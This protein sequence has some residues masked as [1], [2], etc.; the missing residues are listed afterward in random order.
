MEQYHVRQTVKGEKM[1][2][3]SIVVVVLLAFGLALV[4]CDNGMTRGKTKFEGRWV[5]ISYISQGYTDYSFTFSG[6]NFVFR[7]VHL[8]DS[9]RNG[10]YTGTFAFTDTYFTWTPT[11]GENW[12]G[13]SQTYTMNRD[14]QIF[15]GD[16]PP[17]VYPPWGGG[18][19]S[20]PGMFNKQ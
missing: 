2:R 7:M 6:N 20:Y 14:I 3:H 12:T 1:K 17:G 19:G 18:R 13:F 16:P 9:S 8:H 11:Q 4:S 5:D 15:L 10:V